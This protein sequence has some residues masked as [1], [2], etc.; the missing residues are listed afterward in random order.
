MINIIF[1]FCSESP[2]ASAF[3]EDTVTSHE[4]EKKSALFLGIKCFLHQ[5]LNDI[6][7]TH[8]IN[9]NLQII[10]I[11]YREKMTRMKHLFE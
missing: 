11:K 9:K 5:A 2:F 10:D 8:F 1:H 6:W 7:K 3:T 4:G